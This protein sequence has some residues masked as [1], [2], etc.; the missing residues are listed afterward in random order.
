[1]PPTE[2]DIKQ[3]EMNAKLFGGPKIEPP[4]DKLPQDIQKLRLWALNHPKI[5][6][7]SDT[8]FAEELQAMYEA[9]AKKPYPLG[10][11]PLITMVGTGGREVP[12]DTEDMK[13]IMDEKRQQK[14]GFASLS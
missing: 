10:D 12:S 8:F 2:E 13:R 7:E 11:K 9:R 4:Y 6:A 3:A 5:S 1:K 14:V